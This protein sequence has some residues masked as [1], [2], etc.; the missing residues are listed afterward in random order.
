L[1]AGQA[2]FS[3]V[4]FGHTLPVTRATHAVQFDPIDVQA[5]FAGRT[6]FWRD[7]FRAGTN[8]STERKR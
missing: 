7:V 1:A 3:T 8:E 4:L 6:Y 5:G 2:A